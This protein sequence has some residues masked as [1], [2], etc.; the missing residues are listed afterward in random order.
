MHRVADEGVAIHW[1]YKEGEIVS[2]GDESKKYNWIKSLLTILQN[3]TTPEEVMDNS[4]LE[5]F[6]NEV[7]CFTPAGDL[8]TLPRGANAIDFAYEIHTS[9]GNTC[10]GARINGKM[11][12]LKTI[13]KNGDQVDITTSP[14]QHPDAAWERLVIT[15]K[16]KSC[17]KK[18]IKAQEKT[19]FITFGLQLVTSIFSMLDI[20][21]SENLIQYKKFS[22]NS[23]NRFYYN[24]GK[25]IIP[26]NSV[27]MM[28]SEKGTYKVS[29]ESSICLTDFTPGIAIHFE[30]CC[31]PI[32]GDKIIGIFVPKK[33]LVI[34]QTSCPHISKN[35]NVFIRVKW[36]KDDATEVAFISRLRIVISNKTESFA[37]ITNIISSNGA[38]ITNIK[39]EH[40]SI[41]FFDLL[42]DIRVNDIIHLGEIQAALRTCTN[43]RSVR[44]L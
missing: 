7:F 44:R 9:V 23:L 18:Y 4:K 29:N 20:E 15:G 2:H 36:N 41:D 10:I 24:V 3:S 19:E 38:S 16:A 13:L 26:L 6:D 21:F 31:H 32:L 37:I 43:V 27:R 39:V 14:Y 1:S 12:P 33:G 35:K 11:V 30:E 25:G 34:H 28:I 40:R 5:K 22:C 17:I 8:I 42:V